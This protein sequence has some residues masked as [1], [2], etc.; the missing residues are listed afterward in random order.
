MSLAFVPPTGPSKNWT[1]LDPEDLDQRL[2]TL[3]LVR[4]RPEPAIIC[5]HCQYALKPS[6]EAVSKHLWEKHQLSTDARKG[7]NPFVK[8][9]NLPNP[10][11]LPL[12]PD[13]CPPHPY[14]IAQPGVACRQCSFRSTSID[15]VRRHLSKVHGQKKDRQIWFSDLIHENLSLQ[16]WTQ[17]G[18]RGYWIVAASEHLPEAPTA[19]DVSCSPRRRQKVAKLHEEEQQRIVAER[20]QR[21]AI[22]TGTDDLALT[23]NW[24]RRTGW[25][26]T[27]AG[28]DRLLLLRLA[29]H[30]FSSGD[31]MDLGCY[32]T[33]K[34]YSSADDERCLIAVGQAVD[35]FFDRCEDTARNTDHSIRCWLRSQIPDRP[36]KAPFELLG[37][38]RTT[39]T[40]RRFWKRL[41]YFV[42]R[43]HQLD[44]V[45]VRDL[46]HV[47]LSAKLSK[48]VHEIWAVL[49]SN[50]ADS[51]MDR[52][53]MG[54]SL[55][56][57]KLA[58]SSLSRRDQPLV[59]TTLGRRT[60]PMLSS[61]DID[62]EDYLGSSDQDSTDG[63]YDPSDQIDDEYC[64]DQ[65]SSEDDM[66]S[67]QSSR[68]NRECKLTAFRES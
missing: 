14:L 61:H 9:L 21:S 5:R 29:E 34:M 28:V 1:R 47:Q 16:S 42:F 53:M 31:H 37:R 15:L 51:D 45:L 4:N 12:R 49:Q 38:S 35:H 41:M 36:Y 59:S 22:D 6:G 64:D 40:Y 58:S 20:Q 2:A 50:A 17:N 23:S 62:G 65:S 39:V 8:S 54:S 55:L 63:E 3:G 27:F 56:A 13:G 48:A 43:L 25:A 67:V 44:D 33:T 19:T 52:C 7:L 18:P 66:A 30:P 57:P 68:E 26:T 24:M 11:Q 32:G 46:L 60:N 10:N